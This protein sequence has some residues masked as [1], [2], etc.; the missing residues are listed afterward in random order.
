VLKLSIGGLKP[1]TRKDLGWYQELL[2]NRQC[3]MQLVNPSCSWHLLTSSIH[4]HPN[5]FPKDKTVQRL[6]PPHRLVA[7]KSAKTLFVIRTRLLC[8]TV[9]L[10]R[11]ARRIFIQSQ[12]HQTAVRF[13][14]HSRLTSA[15]NPYKGWGSSVGTVT[16]SRNGGIMIRFPA[17]VRD[18]WHTRSPIQWIPRFVVPRR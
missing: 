17:E 16:R 8:V 11:F 14:Q 18:F 5:G 12:N 4:L 9:D 13:P 6:C 2:R 15:L 3:E 7:C 1:C 10:K